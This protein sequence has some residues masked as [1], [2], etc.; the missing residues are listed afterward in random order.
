VEKAREYLA[1]SL[2]IF[3]EIKSPSAELVRKWLAEL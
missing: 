3:E 1:A 2:S